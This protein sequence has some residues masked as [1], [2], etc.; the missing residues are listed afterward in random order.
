MP[1]IDVTSP[2][3]PAMFQLYSNR[4]PLQRPSLSGSVLGLRETGKLTHVY[5]PATSDHPWLSANHF[6]KVNGEPPSPDALRCD[7]SSHSAWQ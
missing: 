5:E 1:Q 7:S 4:S 3:A 6:Y 2:F